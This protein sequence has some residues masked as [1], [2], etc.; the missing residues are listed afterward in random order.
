MLRKSTGA[1]L[2]LERVQL[3]GLSGNFRRPGVD[4]EGARGRVV[5]A[6]RGD[7][8]GESLS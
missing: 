1:G 8:R 6:V 5:G 3:P 2:D 4:Q 7:Y